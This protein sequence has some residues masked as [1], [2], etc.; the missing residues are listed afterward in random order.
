[1]R[2][3]N[4]NYVCVLCGAPL[5]VS[6]TDTVTTI[7]GSSGKPTDRILSKDGVVIHRCELPSRT[8]A[9]SEAPKRWLLVWEESAWVARDEDGVVIM[10]AKNKEEAEKQ[11]ASN[12]RDSGDAINL[13]IE[14][15]DGRFQEE[16]KY[17]RGRAR[18]TLY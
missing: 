6:E 16:R 2:L 5:E 17:P 9:R 10:T 7:A 13:R 12:A 4:G 1:V 8:A 14:G 3:E 15:K 11:V 18:R